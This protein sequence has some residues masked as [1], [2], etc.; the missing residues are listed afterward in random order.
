MKKRMR[1]AAAVMAAVMGMMTL[2]GCVIAFIDYLL[3]I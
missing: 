1:M 3:K 2:G